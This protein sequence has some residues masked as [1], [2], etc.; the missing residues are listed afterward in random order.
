M[1]DAIQPRLQAWVEGLLTTELPQVARVCLDATVSA[2]MDEQVRSAIPPPLDELLHAPAQREVMTTLTT[3]DEESPSGTALKGSISSAVANRLATTFPAEAGVDASAQRDSTAL[4]FMQTH[5]EPIGA[6][7]DATCDTVLP[8]GSITPPM[9]TAKDAIRNTVMPEEVDTPPMTMKSSRTNRGGATAEAAT[10]TID[11]SS[12]EKTPIRRATVAPA[13]KGTAVAG[14]ET[15]GLPRGG[16]R[17][18]CR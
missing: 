2:L 3:L 18:G 4:E 15:A 7:M 10:R 6:A 5:T 8:Q 11:V 12:G 1:I 9:I 16:I 17:N 13:E 14:A